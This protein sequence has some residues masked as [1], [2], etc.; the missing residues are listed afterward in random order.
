MVE[1]F[2]Q[3][4]KDHPDS[5]CRNLVEVLLQ[6]MELRDAARKVFDLDVWNLDKQETLELDNSKN[7]RLKDILYFK[8]KDFKR[9]T[10]KFFEKIFSSCCPENSIENHFMEGFLEYLTYFTECKLREFRSLATQIALSLYTGMLANIS[11]S[12]QNSKKDSKVKVQPI[13]ASLI[14]SISKHY[15][16]NLISSRINDVDPEICKFVTEHLLD[17]YLHRS[18]FAVDEC[19]FLLTHKKNDASIQELHIT[20]YGPLSKLLIDQLLTAIQKDYL[21]DKISKFLRI[22]PGILIKVR[23]EAG[24]SSVDRWIAR[25]RTIVDQNVAVLRANTG[26][27]LK[28]MVEGKD[29]VGSNVIKYFSNGIDFSGLLSDDDESCVLLM[30]I[31]VKQKTKEACIDYIGQKIKLISETD[32]EARISC[33]ARMLS[34]ID[35]F[36]HEQTSSSPYQPFIFDEKRTLNILSCF[37]PVILEW[38]CISKATP[39][40]LN[41]DDDEEVQER[42][43]LA[44]AYVGCI[45]MVM[46]QT[47]QMIS[48][49]KIPASKMPD[50]LKGEILDTIKSIAVSSKTSI[51]ESV[52]KSLTLR[53]TGDNETFRIHLKLISQ[54]CTDNDQS[55]LDIMLDLFNTTKD[56]PSLRQITDMFRKKVSSSKESSLMSTNLFIEQLQKTY[57]EYFEVVYELLEKWKYAKKNEEAH[58]VDIVC[59]RIQEDMLPVFHKLSSLGK[60]LSTDLKLS[61]A[62]KETVCFLLDISVADRFNDREIVEHC[63][64]LIQAQLNYYL[65]N[66][67]S[68][69]EQYFQWREN[70][71]E[72]FTYFLDKRSNP[73]MQPVD[74][75]LVRR[76]VYSYFASYLMVSSNDKIAQIQPSLYKKPD[77]NVLKLLWDFLDDYLFTSDSSKVEDLQKEYRLMTEEK[78]ISGNKFDIE[79]QAGNDSADKDDGK[80]NH[81][82]QIYLRARDYSFVE[83]ASSVIEAAFKLCLC[84]FRSIG[85]TL[86]QRLIYKLLK[87][88]SVYQGVLISKADTLFSGLIKQQAEDKSGTRL[89]FWKFVY[90]CIGFYD[91]QTLRK[92][93]RQ[94]FKVYSKEGYDEKEDRAKYESFCLLSINWAADQPDI[95]DIQKVLPFLKRILFAEE[96]FIRLLYYTQHMLEKHKEDYKDKEDEYLEDRKTKQIT[97]LRDQLAQMC[98]KV[99]KGADGEKA[100]ESRRVSKAVKRSSTDQ[101]PQ[102]EEDEDKGRPSSNSKRAKSKLKGGKAEKSKGRSKKNTTM[103]SEAEPEEKSRSKSRVVSRRSNSTSRGKSSGKTNRSESSDLES[104]KPTNRRKQKEGA[105]AKGKLTKQK[106]RDSPEIQAVRQPK[107]EASKKGKSRGKSRTRK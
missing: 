67:G 30:M 62:A 3:S 74:A 100:G 29:E 54:C 41:T 105:K 13:V 15:F 83:D 94:V 47:V 35:R 93:S 66:M 19:I 61:D 72:Y 95:D 21:L 76:L 65:C 9:K 85:S 33:L 45:L 40:F 32:H 37:I 49:E 102:E 104:V 48:E 89:P 63:L 101:K 16:E 57:D 44:K 92:L 14:K 50:F 55:F 18:A 103:V 69:A 84:I 60:A 17:V 42:Q 75:M 7:L 11:Q 107:K 2:S 64:H 97:T 39:M 38:F 27:L 90:S 12:V 96:R 28:A 6:C 73:T 78:P 80:K 58:L 59:Q 23:D 77:E 4:F 5:A 25:C 70:A 52:K 86:A 22:V 51:R 87:L 34:K 46:L 26:M 81:I 31:S 24:D 20:K 71:S 88:D 10:L 82:E 56:L 79:G 36:R 68:Q 8:D 53:H 98:N 43:P 106:R 1:E 99:T 91:S